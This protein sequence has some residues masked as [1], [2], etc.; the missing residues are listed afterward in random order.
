MVFICEEEEDEEDEED[1]EG[2]ALFCCNKL[3]T[4]NCFPFLTAASIF[5]YMYI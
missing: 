1:E 3:L 4:E 2:K 5:I